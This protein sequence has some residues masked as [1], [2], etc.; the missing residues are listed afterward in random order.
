M[1]RLKRAYEPPAP[2]DGTRVL[3]DRLWPRGVSREDVELDAWTKEAAPSGELREWFDHDPEKWEE[4]RERYRRELEEEDEKRD[5]VERLLEA[6]RGGELTL[7][8][9]ARDTEHNNAVALRE[10]LLEEAEGG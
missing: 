3:V 5:A 6:H 1:I 10:H 9:G 8:Y 2:E 4:F 7:V